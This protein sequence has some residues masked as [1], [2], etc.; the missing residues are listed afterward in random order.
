MAYN[1]QSFHVMRDSRRQKIT[2]CAK[3]GYGY[4]GNLKKKKK[5]RKKLTRFRCL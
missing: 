5:K 3:T 2:F 1:I 4:P